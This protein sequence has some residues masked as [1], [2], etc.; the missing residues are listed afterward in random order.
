M[1]LTKLIRTV[2]NAA[3]DYAEEEIQKK[4]T[5]KAVSK[6][7]KKTLTTGKKSSKTNNAK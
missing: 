6:V 4:N 3:I 1:S 5:K 7:A 2:A